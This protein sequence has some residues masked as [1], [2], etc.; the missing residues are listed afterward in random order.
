MTDDV[1][2]DIERTKPSMSLNDWD[3][4]YDWE[5]LNQDFHIDSDHYDDIIE[6]YSEIKHD[7]GVCHDY[8]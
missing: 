7:Y 8:E 3:K 5:R 2:N 4:T 1:F 6:Q